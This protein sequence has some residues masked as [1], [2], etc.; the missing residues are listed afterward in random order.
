MWRGDDIGDDGESTTAVLEE[1]DSHLS[2][3]T[4]AGLS[5]HPLRRAHGDAVDDAVM[6]SLL[7]HGMRRLGESDWSEHP[8]LL[9]E[10]TG[11][12]AAA[13]SPVL[14]IAALPAA[15]YK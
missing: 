15:L 12:P 11:S 8:L 3:A 10:P 4:L 2:A 1:G 7:A 5:A 6:R 14:R 13:N 9:S